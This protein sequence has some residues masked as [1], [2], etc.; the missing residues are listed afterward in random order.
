MMDR[1]L[2]VSDYLPEDGARLGPDDI[3][4]IR[5]AQHINAVA[6]SLG[7]ATDLARF[8]GDIQALKDIIIQLKP[9]V[10]FN[11]GEGDFAAQV[12]LVA[13]A[14]H[15]PYTGGDARSL[16][17]T[18]NKLW[19]KAVARRHGIPTAARYC[20]NDLQT[21]PQEMKLSGRYILKAVSLDGSVGMGG[22]SVVDCPRV[23]HLSRR[24][25]RLSA[26]HGVPFFAET[27]LSGRELKI[28]VIETQAVLP[29]MLPL[30]EIKFK[31]GSPGFL[32]YG[33]QWDDTHPD[34]R[35]LETRLIP[36]DGLEASPQEKIALD[37]WE[38]FGVSGYARI[39]LK[40]D[41]HGCLHL[42]ELNVNPGLSPD[43]GFTESW[44]A[45]GRRYEEMIDTILK[46][47]VS[48]HEGERAAA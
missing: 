28:G 18:T 12:A 6:E 15:V 9:H 48:R 46:S 5:Q 1:L 8:R 3:D 33:V 40:E 7:F 44:L 19:T 43:A 23:E 27:F 42:L 30:K 2:I 4:T 35:L 10:L 38:L 36:S 21:L 26:K 13:A 29:L 41:D 20:Q 25:E 24:L 47:A 11:M 45:T 34:Q 22:D 32:H 17:L 37:L 14:L 39:D 31:A 16:L